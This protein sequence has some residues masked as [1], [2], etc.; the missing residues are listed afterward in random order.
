LENRWSGCLPE[1]ARNQLAKSSE[2]GHSE[3][4]VTIWTQQFQFAL[5]VLDTERPLNLYGEPEQMTDLHAWGAGL[6]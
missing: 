5:N 2:R 3:G 4:A 1:K 6:G